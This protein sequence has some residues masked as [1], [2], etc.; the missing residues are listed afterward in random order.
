MHIG[1]AA[2]YLSLVVIPATCARFRI[3]DTFK[4]RDF[5]DGFNWETL[6]DP[7]DG[8]VNF[9]DMSTAM[10]SNL[11]FGTYYAKYCWKSVLTQISSLSASEDKFIMRADHAKVVSP[12]D[13]GRDSVRIT[14]QKAWDD[15]TIVLDLSHM[16]EGCATWPAFW[17]LSQQGPWP[18]GGEVD[19]IEGQSCTLT[20][21]SSSCLPLQQLG[22]NLQK[23]NLASL[24]TTSDCIMDTQRP[25][26]G[27]GIYSLS[28][29]P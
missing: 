12:D 14:S 13:R 5:F 17:T 26:S 10:R 11:S 27:Y 25:Q 4:G 15:S 28:I 29:L 16:P 18:R 19:V 9:V 7:T 3:A 1:Y 21:N 22:V 6:N 23:S 2:G 20:Q 24:H 8:R